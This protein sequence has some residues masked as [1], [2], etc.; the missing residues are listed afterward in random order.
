MVD[1]QISKSQFDYL[2]M[3]AK[4]TIGHDFPDDKQYLFQSRL[5][6]YLQAKGYS[7]IAE[8]VRTLTV[9]DDAKEKMAVV[10]LLTTQE[11][12]FFRDITPFEAMRLQ[13]LPEI[14]KKR[15]ITRSLS[16]WSAAC[17][18]GQEPYSLAM[19]IR[20]HFP[21][22]LG[23]NVYIFATDVKQEAIDKAEKGIYNP[24]EINRGLDAHY[25]EKY[26]AEVEGGWLMKPEV[27]N[28]INFYRCNL[29]DDIQ[30]LP[31]LDFIFLRNVLIYF[32]MSSKI[33]VL[34]KIYNL[35][36]PDGY[37]VMGSGE[38]I[39]NLEDM[40]KKVPVTLEDGKHTTVYQKV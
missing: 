39:L 13:L 24:I 20:E 1:T 2:R 40:Y 32:D 30:T 38:V 19:M 21:Q 4:Q 14:I 25:R 5:A 31:P 18:T 9:N 7:S 22:V 26:C 10:T 28:M 3:L 8:L 35:L 16:I 27:A 36:K 12:F 34:L 17:S 11:S 33:N 29:L 37:L 23:W 6:P 15:Q